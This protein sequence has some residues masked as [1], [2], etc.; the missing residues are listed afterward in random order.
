MNFEKLFQ[1]TDKYPC[2]GVFWRKMKNPQTR[3]NTGLEALHIR[4]SVKFF[5]YI[6]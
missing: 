1:K 5:Y 3:I 6:L 4:F 2:F